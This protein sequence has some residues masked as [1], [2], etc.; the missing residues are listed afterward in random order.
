MRLLLALALIFLTG[1]NREDDFKG[2][3]D[4]PAELQPLVDSFVRE[5]TMRGRSISITNLIITY[6]NE[7]GNAICGSCNSASLSTQIQKVITINAG[8]PCWTEPMEL[9]NLLFHELGHCVLGRLHTSERLPNGEPRSLMIDNNVGLYAPCVYQVDGETC[10]DNTFKRGYY[11]D[12]L[13]GENTPV[14][15]WGK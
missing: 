12:E 13:F 11:L 4:V 2:V 6:S 5:A 7:P 9:E 3:Y 14:P 1:C 15:I 10:S 8:T